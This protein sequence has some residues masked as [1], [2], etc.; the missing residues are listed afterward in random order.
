MFP[1]LLLADGQE[2]EVREPYLYTGFKKILVGRKILNSEN[3]NCEIKC[4][5]IVSIDLNIN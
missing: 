3:I 2:F 5:P 1:T 4:L